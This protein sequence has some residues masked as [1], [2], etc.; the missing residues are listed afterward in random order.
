MVIEKKIE[1]KYTNGSGKKYIYKL[2]E[3]EGNSVKE[4]GIEIIREDT[5]NEKV[6]NELKE[7]VDNISTNK[8][9]ISQLL[10]ILSR[11]PV[12]PIHLKDIICDYVD[13]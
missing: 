4:Y 3:Q 5:E 9:E 10:E 6:V 1:I 2:T 11:N 12:S 13:K 8:E 7:N